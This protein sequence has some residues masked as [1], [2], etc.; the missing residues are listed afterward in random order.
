MEET[1]IFNRKVECKIDSIQS[2]LDQ[3]YDFKSVHKPKIKDPCWVAFDKLPVSNE[4]KILFDLNIVVPNDSKEKKKYLELFHDISGSTSSTI[5]FKC[6][7]VELKVIDENSTSMIIH[8]FWKEKLP[9]YDSFIADLRENFFPLEPMES[10][11][12]VRSTPDSIDEDQTAS[13]DG[14]HKMSYDDRLLE[15]WNLGHPTE[16]IAGKLKFEKKVEKIKASTVRNRISKLR[17]H[18]GLEKVPK[19]IGG[20]N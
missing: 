16:I 19:R 3:Y 8:S 18:Y 6:G 4:K 20:N 5:Y 12:I 1:I 17:K 15:L 10:M 13:E 9:L 2:W 14:F 11:N 7:I